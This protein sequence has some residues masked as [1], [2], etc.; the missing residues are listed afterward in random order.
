M[1]RDKRQIVGYDIAFDKSKNRI[2]NLVNFSPKANKYYSDSYPIYSEIL[3]DGLHTSLKNKS[4]TYTVEG[5]NSEFRH[6]IPTLTR[7]LYH[8]TKLF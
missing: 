1:S 6:H 5:V 3:H 2:Q 4:Q 7:K 8:L